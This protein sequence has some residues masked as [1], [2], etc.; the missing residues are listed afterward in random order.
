MNVKLR[1]TVILLASICL[2]AATV[3][4]TEKIMKPGFVNGDSMNPTLRDRDLFFYVEKDNINRGDVIV[5]YPPYNKTEDED[6]V[7]IKRVIGLPGEHLVIKDSKVYINDTLLTENYLEEE[8]F[9]ADI[10]ITIPSGE[11]FAMGDNRNDSKDSR[12]FGTIK[13]NNVLGTVGKLCLRRK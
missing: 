13:I 12:D 8:Q 3:F 1:N 11:I 7:F 10:D 5:F 2:A 4:V 6:E 9:E